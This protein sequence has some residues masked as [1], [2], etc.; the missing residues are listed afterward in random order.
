M[1]QSLKDWTDDEDNFDLLR[2]MEDGGVRCTM[3]ESSSLPP[4]FAGK[5]FVLTGTLP[6]LGR[7]EAKTMIKDRGGKVSSSV[8]KKT[9]FLLLGAEAGSKLEEAKKFNVPTI[10]EA[11]FRKMCAG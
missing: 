6:A 7:E 3:P 10:D 4:I 2:K 1:A 11:I 5:T 9:S 8:S